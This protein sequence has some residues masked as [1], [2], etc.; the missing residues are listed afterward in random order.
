MSESVVP[1][2]KPSI[3]ETERELDARSSLLDADTDIGFRETVSIIRRVIANFWPLFP[4]R[5]AVKTLLQ[6]G[7]LLSIALLLPWQAKAVIDHVVLSTPI[8]EASGYPAYIDPVLGALQGKDPIEILIWLTTIAFGMVLTLGFYASGGA[9]D[10]G[11]ESRM[12]D[13]HDI[14]TTTENAMNEGFSHNGGLWG[15]V[16]FTLQMRLTQ[17]VNHVLRSQLFSRIASLSMTQLE[18]QRIGDSVYRVMYDTPAVTTLFYEVLLT[19][20]GSL[21][22]YVGALLSLMSAYP[23]APEVIWIS[24]SILPIWLTLSAL[25]SRVT[26]RR[27]QA[28]RASGSITTSTVEEGM[29]NI[30][31]V[32]S[33]GGRGKEKERFGDDSDES[34]KR[35]RSYRLVAIIVE[36]FGGFVNAILQTA[37]FVVISYNV[38]DGTM[39]PGDYGAMFVFWGMM[40]GPAF[41]VAGLWIRLQGNVAGI[42]RVF[43][44]MDIPPEDDMGHVTL[45]PI[46]D[47]VSMRG[48]SLVYPDGRPAVSNIDLDA[49]VGEIVAFVGPTGAGKTSLAYL[50][51]RFHAATSGVVAVDGHDVADLTL[52]SL[53]SQVTYVFQ[54]TQLLSESIG[55]NIRYGR[56]DATQEDVERVARISGVHD[57]IVSLPQGYD[58]KLGG[59]AASKLS[60]GQKQRIAIARGLLR[61]AK[62]LIL[63][64]PTSALDPETE[65][66]LVQSLHEA[67]KDRLVIIIAHRLSTIVQADR[68]VFLEDGRVVEQGSHSELMAIDEG[69]YRNFVGL[70]TNAST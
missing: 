62:I 22:I 38:I 49:K 46:T 59:A 4:V 2:A 7:A 43:A 3:R 44:L 57:F 48:A 67:A 10:D 9:R 61:D 19:P 23:H 40:R 21:S 36:H 32:Q 63:D 51:P 53:R 14:A 52:E 56:L 31:A 54:E 58:T 11:V 13:G 47:G 20:T 18:D 70:Q 39:T 1:G 30:L 17:A 29:D 66:Y 35:H 69:H 42:R 68:I 50:I 55:D 26:R 25:F 27:G 28:A 34:F 5:L 41:A 65:E 8:E 37:V 45:P 6:M 60:V 24:A 33:L 16:E 12:E 15:Y 64:E